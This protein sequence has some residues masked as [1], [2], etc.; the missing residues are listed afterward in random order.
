MLD[1]LDS[2]KA[3]LDKNS[4]KVRTS[5]SE[6][7]KTAL[8]IKYSSPNKIE[9]E[10]MACRAIKLKKAGKLADAADIMEEAFNKC[11]DLRDKYANHVK[12]WRCGIS[13]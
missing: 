1:A 10:K 4:H 2:W 13:M 6:I 5:Y 7:S 11:P 12:L 8:G 9:G 3:G